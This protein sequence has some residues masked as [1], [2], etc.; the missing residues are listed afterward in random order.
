M[1]DWQQFKQALW[2]KPRTKAELDEAI[3]GVENHLDVHRWDFLNT[4][5]FSSLLV[6]AFQAVGLG[7]EALIWAVCVWSVEAVLS[8]IH[9]RLRKERTTARNVMRRLAILQVGSFCTLMVW[10]PGLLF[11][12]GTSDPMCTTLVLLSWSGS[13]MVVTNQNGAIPRIA[14]TSGMVPGLL[15]LFVPTLYAEKPAEFALAGLGAVLV[16]LVARS[17][18]SNL[19]LNKKLFAVQADKDELITELEIARRAAEADRQ[20]ADKANTAKTEFLAMMSHEIRTPM[21]GLLGM[22]QMLLR[23][24]LS[25][26]QRLYADTIVDSGD[27]LLSLLNDTLDLSR[28]EAGHMELDV[29][30]ESPRRILGQLQSLWGPRAHVEGLDF[31]LDIEPS[32]PGTAELDSRKVQQLLSN[33]IGNAI[34]FTETGSVTVRALAP[35]DGLLRFQVRDTGPGISHSAQRRI[36]EKFTQ[37]DTS[38]SRRY[39]GSGLGLTLCKEFVELMG[40]RIYVESEEGEGSCFVA[41]VPCRFLAAAPEREPDVESQSRQFSAASAGGGLHVLV[42]DDHPTN[43]KLMRAFL[44]RYGYSCVIVDDGQAAVDALAA[45]DFDIVLMDVQMPVMDGIT[46]TAE[47]RKLPESKA[48]IPILAITANAMAGQREEYIEKGFDGYVSKPIDA[49]LL[50][51]EI[52]RVV[53]I[54]SQADTKTAASA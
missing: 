52:R 19:R 10:A 24:D 34:K 35:R 32:V 38:T 9:W 11:G 49:D 22:A 53:G 48:G 26:E 39:G 40:G 2:G 23:G 15:I 18:I 46:A 12:M 1:N 45:G 41:E 21:N 31:N 37:A 29:D 44:E 7:L 36:F 33:L 25:D 54:G 17:T 16:L 13:L 50:Q 3:A 47:V 28:I 42:A 6:L 30:E 20:R 5:A 43:Q 27:T 4:I 8:S 51:A 14:I